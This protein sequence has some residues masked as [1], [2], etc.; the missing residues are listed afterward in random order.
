MLERFHQH[1]NSNLN[2][3]TVILFSRIIFEKPALAAIPDFHQI[4]AKSF[5]TALLTLLKLY[6]RKKQSFKKC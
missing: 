6:D 5:F 1:S 3:F 2:E 4:D